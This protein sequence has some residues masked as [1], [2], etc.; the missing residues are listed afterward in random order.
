M[1]DLGKLGCFGMLCWCGGVGLAAE[2]TGT[3]AP[4][5]SSRL[6]PL[7][8]VRSR[9]GLRVREVRWDAVLGRSWAVLEDVDHPEWPLWAELTEP[10]GRSATGDSRSSEHAAASGAGAGPSSSP[11]PVIPPPQVVHYGDRVTL[12]RNERNVRIQMNATAEGS[13]AVGEELKLRVIGTGVNGDA[14]WRVTGIVRGPGN[15]EME[16]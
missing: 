3:V 14:G 10:I 8:V 7:A 5:A 2:V 13:G 16:P 6:A 11:Q 15:V 1:R 4:Q 12:W 9:A